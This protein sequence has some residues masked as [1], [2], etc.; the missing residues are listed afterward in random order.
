VINVLNDGNNFFRCVSTHI[1]GFEDCHLFLRYR[2]LLKCFHS[3]NS[4]E[5]VQLATVG[6]DI[7]SNLLEFVGSTF[8]LNVITSSTSI[9]N[10]VADSTL[11]VF[12]DGNIAGNIIQDQWSI[13]PLFRDQQESDTGEES[14]LL[15]ED[16]T[17]NRSMPS[18]DQE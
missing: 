13:Q 10:A 8:R 4:E 11:H 6:E 17:T 2:A 16:L 12:D 7:S 9:T 5:L 1:F 14:A 3:L 15:D 18:Q